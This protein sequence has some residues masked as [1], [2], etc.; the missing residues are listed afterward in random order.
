MPK[1]KFPEREVLKDALARMKAKMV[2]SEKVYRLRVDETMKRAYNSINEIRE[3]EEK[4]KA[5]SHFTSISMGF[6][7]DLYDNVVVNSFQF[8]E[9]LR[10]YTETLE[11][12]CAKLDKARWK[13][14]LEATK[15]LTEKSVKQQE[16]PMKKEPSYRA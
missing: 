13:G 10:L 6:I 8:V 3:S 12:Y 9:D 2:T 7:K 5:G 11:K 16:Q 4:N 1:P 15:K 14:I